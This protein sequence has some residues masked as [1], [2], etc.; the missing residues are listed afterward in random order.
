VITLLDAV[1]LVNHA[2]KTVE[3]LKFKHETEGRP[4][5][6]EALGRVATRIHN[7]ARDLRDLAAA[8]QP[9]KP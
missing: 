3:L 4:V 6:A 7:A 5:L 9:E 8:P 1:R 2:A